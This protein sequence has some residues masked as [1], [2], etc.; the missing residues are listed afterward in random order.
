MLPCACSRGRFGD[1]WM[2][3][4]VSFGAE[5]EGAARASAGTLVRPNTTKGC[6]LRTAAE[7]VTSERHPCLRFVG[8]SSATCSLST[9]YAVA[10]L[11]ALCDG[12]TH[13]VYRRVYYSTAVCSWEK[14]EALESS[15]RAWACGLG[16]CSRV[17]H[18]APQ[19][20]QCRVV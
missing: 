8:C 5:A 18:G 16:P 17:Q 4:T 15:Q 6:G 20:V 7:P 10:V 12:Q 9:L 11:A 3:M 1:A 14:A 19:G 13:S 2:S